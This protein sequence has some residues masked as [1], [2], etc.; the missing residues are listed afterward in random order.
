MSSIAE[1]PY[2]PRAL[3]GS[4]FLENSGAP[5]PGIF[6]AQAHDGPTKSWLSGAYD[7]EVEGPLEAQGKQG[8]M[9]AAFAPGLRQNAP[10]AGP[11]FNKRR[12][13]SAATSAVPTPRPCQPQMTT[14]EATLSKKLAERRALES[15]PD[16]GWGPVEG[17]AIEWSSPPASPRQVSQE[18]KEPKKATSTIPKPYFSLAEAPAG[19]SPSERLVSPR[20]SRGMQQAEEFRDL[21]G[22]LGDLALGLADAPPVPARQK[23]SSKYLFTPEEEQDLAQSLHRGQRNLA[24]LHCLQ[25]E[26]QELTGSLEALLRLSQSLT[27]VST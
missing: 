16:G 1:Y 9:V 2:T 25:E 8:W 20:R 13:A 26:A 10:I 21:P 7:L 18:E 22:E 24:E 12:M 19:A 6:A 27:A 3:R 4:E 5:H 11:Y 17:P 23:A 15:R 14:W